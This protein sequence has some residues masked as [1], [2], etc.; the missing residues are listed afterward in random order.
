MCL[1][2]R[3][4]LLQTRHP[5]GRKQAA[6]F[7]V[8]IRGAGR[9]EDIL[10]HNLALSTACMNNNNENNHNHNADKMLKIIATLE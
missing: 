3:G 5:S 6:A 2:E 4:S 10:N 8:R 1:S 9:R 7:W